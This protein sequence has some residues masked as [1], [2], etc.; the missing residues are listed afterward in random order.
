[1]AQR[2]T[3]Q[4]SLASRLNPLFLLDTQV[5][6]PFWICLLFFIAYTI[7]S[8]VRNSHFG[9]FGFDLGINNQVVWEYSHFQ[10]PITTVDSL[11]LTSYVPK[12]AIHVELIYALLAPFYWIWS[13]ANTLLF[14]Q[15]LFVCISGIPIFLLAKKK[16][17]NTWIQY[18]LLLGYLTFYGVQNAL[19]FDAHS[20]SF[21]SSFLAWFLYFMD[22]ENLLWTTLFFFLAITSKE[23]IAGITF[24]VSIV[25]YIST[26]R[27]SALYFAGAS[28]LYLGVVFGIYFP[29]FVKGGYRFSNSDLFS[30]VNPIN[31]FNTTGKQEIIFYSLAWFGFLAL[32]NPLFLIPAIGDIASYFLLGTKVGGAQTLFEQYHITLAPLLAWATIYT[33]SKR[34]WLNTKFIAVDLVI[35]MIAFQYVLHLP[36]SYLSKSWFWT[37]PK[38]TT[39][40]EKT[41]KLIPANASVVAQN[42]LVPALSQRKDIFVL[43]PVRKN[44]ATNS[45]CGKTTCD[46]FS[47]SGNPTYLLIDTSK[48]WDTRHFLENPTNFINGISDLEK[49]GYIK[50]ASRSDNTTLYL[51]VK[52]PL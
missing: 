31:L 32:L 14:L 18:A 47:W 49:E 10:I 36:L 8:V 3:K 30:N 37:P 25:Y 28:L 22:G 19:W 46:W 40:I 42:N 13:N 45:P 51:V 35:C 48:E 38:S 11:G 20:A 41:I 17:L 1:M 26:K 52:K 39:S 27:K 29:H 9:S 6:F 44:F 23:N 4:N 16:G 34:K 33:I 2:K 21:A 15:S 7:L 50:K 12:F 5:V 24:L 43:W